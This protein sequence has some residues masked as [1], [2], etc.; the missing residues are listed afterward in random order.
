MGLLTPSGPLG[1][2]SRSVPLTQGCPAGKAPSF[3]LISMN[4][5]DPNCLRAPSVSASY[6]KY[7]SA[8]G[9]LP[10]HPGWWEVALARP[11]LR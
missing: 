3:C 10:P 9:Q 6:E 5:G 2:T 1:P 7:S 11:V 4:T 8:F